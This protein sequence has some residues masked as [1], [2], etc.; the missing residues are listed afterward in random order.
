M[1]EQTLETDFPKLNQKPDLNPTLEFRI[2]L[3]H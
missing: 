1:L 2:T 3:I